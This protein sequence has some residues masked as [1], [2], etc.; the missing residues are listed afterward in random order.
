MNSDAGLE[1]LEVLEQLV[2]DPTLEDIAVRVRQR[3]S[4]RR[5]IGVGLAAAAIVLVGV[6]VGL[7]GGSQ[8]VEALW[9]PIP[10]PPNPEL[11]VAA[12]SLC[13]E[14]RP[15]GSTLPPLLLID[16]RGSAAL[17]V[18]AS[19]TSGTVA[20]C[21]L[22]ATDANWA[23]VDLES[24]PFNAYTF[25]GTTDDPNV[26]SMVIEQSDGTTVEAVVQDGIFHFWWPSP[27]HFPG[28]TLRMLDSDGAT[29]ETIP[30]DGP[31][32]TPGR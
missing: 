2:F 21:T 9:S 16:Q 24:S 29:L 25:I 6:V 5:R 26:E 30:I 15:P 12:K 1:T 14:T 20:T 17:A 11:E 7:P 32:A 4:K 28:G 8:Q 10:S 23:A 3:Q 13:E 22:V 18:F 19:Q 27:D 31:P